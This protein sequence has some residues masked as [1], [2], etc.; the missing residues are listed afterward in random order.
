MVLH[1]VID[2]AVAFCE[3]VLA[4]AGDAR[5][6]SATAPKC[7]RCAAVSE[8]LVQVFVNLLTNACQARP[9]PMAGSSSRPRTP[10]T[11][12]R[13]RMVVVVIED[14]GTGI[15]PEH[16]AQVFAPFFTTKGE[17]NGTGL[18][19]SIVKSIVEATAA[20]SGS[21]VSSGAAP[22]SS[23]SSPSAVSPDSAAVLT[24][25]NACTS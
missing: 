13:A 24:R 18:G 12:G 23:S 25:A 11:D 19:L 22:A 20:R 2:Q 10:M 21:T 5:R 14:N 9:R 4:A 1:G 6:A 17:K 15:A 7:S 16:V 8:Q 3:H